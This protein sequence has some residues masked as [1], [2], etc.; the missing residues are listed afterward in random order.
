MKE[1]R[2]TRFKRLA[3]ARVNKIIKMVR[4]LGN[5]SVTT[6]YAYEPDQI[7]QIFTAIQDELN[8]ARSRFYE[9]GKQNR[10]RFTLSDPPVSDLPE[11]REPNFEVMLPDGTMLRAVGFEEDEYPGIC[12][13]ARSPGKPPAIICLIEYNPER[14]EGHRLYIGAYQ[15]HLDDPKYYEP[16]VAERN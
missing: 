6:I 13:Y 11:E 4:L 9:A 7:V 10:K 2:S 3:E 12:I 16:Y 5:L 14:P 15:S 1:A 8:K